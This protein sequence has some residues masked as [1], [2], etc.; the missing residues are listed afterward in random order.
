MLGFRFE[1]IFFLST[2]GFFDNFLAFHRWFKVF[3]S[4]FF[5]SAAVVSIISTFFFQSTGLRFLATLIFL[6]FFSFFLIVFGSFLF[7]YVFRQGH[8]LAIIYVKEIIRWN[9]LKKNFF[10]LTLVQILTH[11]EKRQKRAKSTLDEDAPFRK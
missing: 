2:A 8:I 5:L 7:A 1:I 9:H 6:N 10:I 11:R 3:F 4:N